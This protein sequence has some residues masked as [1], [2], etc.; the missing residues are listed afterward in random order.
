MLVIYKID[1]WGAL[2]GLSWT[3]YTKTIFEVLI[4]RGFGIF[5]PRCCTISLSEG[6]AARCVKLPPALL[7]P[8][9][10]D[11]DLRIEEDSGAQ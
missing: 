4:L 3:H 5:G 10:L 7:V 1:V 8:S 9:H 11:R 2:V 6:M